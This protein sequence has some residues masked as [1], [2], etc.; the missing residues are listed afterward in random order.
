MKNMY[1]D[2][3][4]W[5]IVQ[6]VLNFLNKVILYRIRRIVNQNVTMQAL[7]S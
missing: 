7:L 1:K 6:F 2:S 4:S 3:T 5:T